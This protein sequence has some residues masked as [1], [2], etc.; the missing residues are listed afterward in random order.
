MGD[1]PTSVMVALLPNTVDW[2]RIDLPHMTLVYA[3]E[4]QDLKDSVHDRLI[5]TAIDIS[6]SYG[7]VTTKVLKV[8]LF[9]ENEDT[10]VFRLNKT[11]Q[12]T[13]MRMVLETWNASV[14]PFNPHATIGP[15]GSFQPPAPQELVFDRI[16]VAW[17][18]QL[19]VSNLMG[20]E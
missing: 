18:D 5:K 12:L 4:I 3:G 19:W 15:V 20:V 6:L 1:F 9:G 14:Y 2:C 16:A 13:A 17:G 8:D 7:P 11:P 10:E